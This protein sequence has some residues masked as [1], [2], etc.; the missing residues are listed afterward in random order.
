MLLATRCAAL[1]LSTVLTNGLSLV[2]YKLRLSKEK[3][4]V[5]YRVQTLNMGISQHLL[6]G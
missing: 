5:G 3:Q 2:A 6:E 4:L 1:D